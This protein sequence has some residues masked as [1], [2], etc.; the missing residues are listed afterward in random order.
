MD[1]IRVLAVCSYPAEAAATRYR[2]AQF[3]E[4]LAAHGI[5]MTLRPFLDGSRF[6]NFYKRGR[7]VRNAA[8]LIKPAFGRF[9]DALSVR[10]Y[11]L[12]F[13][14]REAMMFGPPVFEWLFGVVGRVPIV[15]DLDDATYVPYT[16]P[17]YGR[18]GSALKFF[19]K[20]DQL[21]D[22]ATY[23]ISC[24]RF[25]AEYVQ[26]RNKPTSIVPTVIDTEKFAPVDRSNRDPVTIGWIG[27][28]STYPFLQSLFPVLEKLAANNTF[29]L[30]IVGSGRDTHSLSF[31][32]ESLPWRLDREVDDFRSF[33]I[34]LYPMV[35][36]ANASHDWLHGKSCFKA[37]QYMTA[38]LPFVVTPAGN[39][40]ETGLVGQT[41]FAA[42][43][44]TEWYESLMKLLASDGL[45]QTM[46]EKG[47]AFA[48]E[49]F[50]IDQQVRKLADI[51]QNACRGTYAK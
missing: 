33:D 39:C 25:V 17:T 10:K 2:L 46:G 44:D 27:T 28:H 49:H 16:S 22:L 42:S 18:L 21:I 40:G 15:L 20:T 32:V 19:G 36:A 13:V 12:V 9:A 41:H 31:E 1:R 4:P 51:F 48:L 34:G 3:V 8:G 11:D 50:T 23:V 47:R 38:G 7:I 26:K 37:V 43:S 30:K 6:A 29:K 5:D 24:N 35:V 45:R 14:Q